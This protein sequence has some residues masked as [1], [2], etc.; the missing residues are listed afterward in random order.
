MDDFLEKC[1]KISLKL[2]ISAFEY[3]DEL[4]RNKVYANIYKIHIWYFFY[5]MKIK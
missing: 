1:T 3:T 2:G 4:S 5:K